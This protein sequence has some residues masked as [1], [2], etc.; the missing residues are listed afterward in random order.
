MATPS[1]TVRPVDPRIIPGASVNAT[2]RSRQG[3]EVFIATVVSAPEKGRVRVRFSDDTEKTLPLAHVTPR[4]RGRRALIT[5]LSPAELR[6][7]ITALRAELQ[8]AID[9]KDVA[10]QKAIRRKL[11]TRRHK[12]GVSGKASITVVSKPKAEELVGHDLSDL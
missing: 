10:R 5:A 2:I 9:A 12:G 1:R 6:G 3:A 7:E 8:D 4:V 11:R